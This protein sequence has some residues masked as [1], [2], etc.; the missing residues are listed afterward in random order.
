MAAGVPIECEHPDTVSC[1]AVG[2]E[3]SILA[4]TKQELELQQASHLKILQL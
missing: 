3:D 2:E 1:D 4:I